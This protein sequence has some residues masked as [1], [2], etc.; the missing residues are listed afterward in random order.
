MCAKTKFAS[1]GK[2][3]FPLRCSVRPPPRFRSHP[4][5]HRA[6]PRVAFSA[7][8][9]RSV[10]FSSALFPPA[11]TPLLPTV[12]R[13]SLE[14]RHPQL[15]SERVRLGDLVILPPTTVLLALLAALPMPAQREKTRRRSHTVGYLKTS[16]KAVKKCSVQG[17]GGDW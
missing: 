4:P 9:F 12:S 5:S 8:L 14:R 1:S 11:G 15:G 6:V 3:V 7:A 16:G 2:S 17:W 10:A 13:C